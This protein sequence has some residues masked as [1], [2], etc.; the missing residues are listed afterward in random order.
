[1]CSKT[2]GGGVKTRLV[3]CKQ[4]MAQNHVVQRPASKCPSTKPPDKKPCNTKSCVLE[5]ERP[6]IAASNT[7]YVQ[8]NPSKKKVTL[9]IGGQA[10]VFWGTQIKIKCPVKRFNRTKIQWAKDHN[11]ISNSKKYKI[12]KKGALRIQDVTHRDSGIYTC[13][14]GLSTANLMLSVKPRPG[15]FLS[16]EEIE[17]Q[18]TN[19]VPEHA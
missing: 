9:K 5:S 4:V 11:Y 10:V 18:N 19:R 14:A 6:H 16:S 3:E 12:S 13:V 2:C 8:Q 1:Q 17:R 7:S 15:E